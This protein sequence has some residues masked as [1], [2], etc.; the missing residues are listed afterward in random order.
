MHRAL[1][2]QGERF[3]LVLLDPPALI[4][5]RKYE[6]E[7]RQAYYRLN[8]LGLE[9]LGPD[10]MLVTSSCSFHMGRNAFLRTHYRWHA[11]PDAACSC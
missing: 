6:K 4:Q 5:R 1:C 3:D 7:D 8:R 9:V 11:V 2:E 10:K